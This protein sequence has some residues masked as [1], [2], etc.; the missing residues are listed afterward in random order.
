MLVSGRIC[1]SSDTCNVTVFKCISSHLKA[2]NL[3]EPQEERINWDKMGTLLFEFLTALSLNSENIPIT[4][5]ATDTKLGQCVL[6]W[7]I[8][9]AGWP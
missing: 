6:P 9:S 3:P 1:N 4:C 5:S 7:H 8:D 2:D